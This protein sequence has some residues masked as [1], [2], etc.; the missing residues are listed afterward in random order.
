MNSKI[1]DNLSG[2]LDGYRARNI[3]ILEDTLQFDVKDL[4]KFLYLLVGFA[5]EDKGTKKEHEKL[6]LIESR[7]GNL[8]TD[9]L[10]RLIEFGVDLNIFLDSSS[11]TFNEKHKNRIKD[12]V[13]KYIDICEKSNNQELIKRAIKIASKVELFK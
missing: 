5:N 2:F 6:I 7:F 4:E 9:I 10:S 1:E 11:T 8:K 12:V 3:A 13:L